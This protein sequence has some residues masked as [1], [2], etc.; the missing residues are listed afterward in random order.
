MGRYKSPKA[1][2][3]YA[4]DHPICE[5]CGSSQ[6]IGCRI[7]GGVHHIVKRSQGGGDHM[8]NLI[9]LC[10][11]CH[12]AAHDGELTEDELTTRKTDD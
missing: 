11:H 10:T 2:K 4:S 3:D 9:T 1:L 5:V 8:E 6:R 7:N 12:T